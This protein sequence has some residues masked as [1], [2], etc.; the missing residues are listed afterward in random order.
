MT[1]IF[2]DGTL[3]GTVK[4]GKKF[5]EKLISSRRDGKI[6]RNANVSFS[7]KEDIVLFN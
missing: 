3:Y 6:T 4:D 2:V 5:A 7:E 1:D